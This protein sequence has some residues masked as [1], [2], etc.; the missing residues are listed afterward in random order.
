MA[1]RRREQP[2][3]G[4]FLV[5]DKPRGITSHDV[6][7]AARRW[8]GTRR[9]GHLGT[10]DPQATGV[11]PLAVR[12]ATKLV[13][14]LEGGAKVYVGAIQLG[15]RTDTLDGDGE[16]VDRFAGDLPGAAA[17]EAALAEFE[18]EILQTPPMFSALKRGGVPLHRLARRGEHVERAPRRVRVER[19]ALAG[20]EPP[21]VH[22]EVECSPGTYVRSL[23]ADLGDRLGCGAYL[24]SLRRTRSGPFTLE[25]AAPLDVLEEE[26]AAGKLA[27]RLVSEVEAL[28]MPIYS[29][30]EE[31]ARRVSHGGEVP[32]PRARFPEGPGTRVAALAPDGRLIA[33]MELRADFRLRPL[34]VMPQLAGA[35]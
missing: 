35:P 8:L 12:D 6:V 16:V 29:L 34:R 23:A 31:E 3:P 19:F 15:V 7:D 9:V 24:E 20:Y 4:G 32:V 21:R 25:Q 11:L 14:F 22:I 17:V 28:E 2:G 13:P 30:G 26:A 5:V 33:V 27:E 10:L 18:G 1:K